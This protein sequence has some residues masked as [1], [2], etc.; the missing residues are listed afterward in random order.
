MGTGL[1]SAWSVK[2]SSLHPAGLSPKTCA[3]YLKFEKV[4]QAP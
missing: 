4:M 1:R 2:L 3:K